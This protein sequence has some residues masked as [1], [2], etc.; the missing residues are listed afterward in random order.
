MGVV[1]LPQR[2]RERAGV[3]ATGLAWQTYSRL[4]ALYSMPWGTKSGSL[5]SSTWSIR[6]PSSLLL[7]T[8]VC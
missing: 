5:V 4:L 2:H 1:V 6:A 8:S 3:P 7:I